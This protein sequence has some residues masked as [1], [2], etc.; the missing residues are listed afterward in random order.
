MALR[1]CPLDTRNSAPR[2][3]I[4]APPAVGM[5]ITP[6]PSHLPEPARPCP[7]TNTGWPSVEGGGIRC[8]ARRT[9]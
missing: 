2:K 6:G 4:Q 8:L 9:E 7:Q 3:F 5:M 1:I